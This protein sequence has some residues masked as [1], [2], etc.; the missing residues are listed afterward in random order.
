MNQCLAS[1]LAKYGI[2][3]LAKRQEV[4]IRKTII[5]IKCF[6]ID[7]K[8]LG[9]FIYFMTLSKRDTEYTLPERR[10]CALRYWLYLREMAAE[11]YT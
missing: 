9:L 8:C 7:L 10:E 3:Q 1:N 4:I 6:K 2:Q 11:A 5:Y